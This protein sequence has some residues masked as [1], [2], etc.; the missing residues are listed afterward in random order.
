MYQVDIDQLTRL[1]SPQKGRGLDDGLQFYKSSYR[2]QKGAGLGGIFGSIARH[3][4]PFAKNVLFPAA[5]KYLAPHAKI[6][7][8]S[9]A[10]D[11]LSGRNVRE[12]IKDRGSTAIKGIGHDILNQ[13]GTGRTRKRKINKL[14][15]LARKRKA[16]KR[17]KRRGT[18]LYFS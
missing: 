10:G 6:A 7:A 1:Y 14:A 8:R 5:K 18:P 2:R 16:V 11:I 4:I 12:S 15:Q 9:L 3:L 17:K 13:S